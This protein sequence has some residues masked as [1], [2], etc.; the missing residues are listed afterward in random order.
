M[1]VNFSHIYHYILSI[2]HFSSPHFHQQTVPILNLKA[3]CYLSI[4]RN[5]TLRSLPLSFILFRTASSSNYRTDI[6]TASHMLALKAEHR[7][8]MIN[9][10]N[11]FTFN[12]CI[13]MWNTY[14]IERSCIT[15]S[16]NHLHSLFA[17]SIS[18]SG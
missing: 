11:C 16:A 4:I 3:H 2:A 9:I 18:F 14:M 15:Q 13:L 17:T 5:N 1:K 10:L 7:N 12:S 8:E 6:T